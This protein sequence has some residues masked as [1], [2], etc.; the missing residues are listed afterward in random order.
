MYTLQDV[1]RV[2]GLMRVGGVET[3]GVSELAE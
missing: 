2:W 3:I 1:L